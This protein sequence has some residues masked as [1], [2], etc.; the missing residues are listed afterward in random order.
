[1]NDNL[2]LHEYG[3]SIQSRILGHHYLRKVA[4]PSLLG[5]WLEDKDLNEHKKEWYE[6]QANR[7]SNRKYS[8][9]EWDEKH[10]LTYSYSWYWVL[11]H[12]SLRYSWWLLF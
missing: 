3:H 10:P 4:L 2:F 11:A 8:D 9:V 7:L 6:T 5:Q 12:P 1:M